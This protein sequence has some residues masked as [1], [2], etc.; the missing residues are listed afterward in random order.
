M[1]HSP[2]RRW[3]WMPMGRLAPPHLEKPINERAC[4]GPNYRQ[5][6]NQAYPSTQQRKPT[7]LGLIAAMVLN[8]ANRDDLGGSI[9]VASLAARALP[10]IRTLPVAPQDFVDGGGSPK[11]P[12]SSALAGNALRLGV[13]AGV[14]SSRSTAE[15]SWALPPF[16]GESRVDG[17]VASEAILEAPEGLTVGL[18]CGGERES[19]CSA[20]R[21]L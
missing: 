8:R 18:T 6:Q 1:S 7:A 2:Q 14:F 21:I 11:R 12:C 15:S 17:A 3:M 4:H 16:D 19:I 5:H 10:R 20:L 9:T 13:G